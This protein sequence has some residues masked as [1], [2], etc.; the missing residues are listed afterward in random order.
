MKYFPAFIFMATFVSLNQ[1]M[2][3]MEQMVFLDGFF[4]IKQKLAQYCQH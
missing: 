3:S 4:I 2:I 1:Q